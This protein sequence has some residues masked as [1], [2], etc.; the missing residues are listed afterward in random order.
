MTYN[1]YSLFLSPILMFTCNF[2]ITLYQPRR[3]CVGV[4]RSQPRHHHPVHRRSRPYQRSPQPMTTDGALHL[5]STT[6]TTWDGLAALRPSRARCF[7]PSQVRAERVARVERE[8]SHHPLKVQ[9]MALH[10]MVLVLDLK[11]ELRMSPSE[12]FVM[13]PVLLRLLMEP[14]RRTKRWRGED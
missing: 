12:V 14:L 4:K 9:R 1:I 2:R 6:D 7:G 13:L 5:P 10:G 3:I 8:A 11:A